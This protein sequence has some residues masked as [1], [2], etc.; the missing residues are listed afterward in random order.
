MISARLRKNVNGAIASVS[1][2]GIEV[3]TEQLLHD[4]LA[5]LSARG[6]SAWRDYIVSRYETDVFMRSSMAGEDVL[7]LVKSTIRA[8]V[9]PWRHAVAAACLLV[10]AGGV[11]V[12]I[13][14]ASSQSVGSERSVTIEAPEPSTMTPEEI[15][16]VVVNRHSFTDDRMG[17]FFDRSRFFR[18]R[19]AIPKAVLFAAQTSTNDDGS[20]SAGTLAAREFLGSFSMQDCRSAIME[21]ANLV[22]WKPSDLLELLEQVMSQ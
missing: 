2:G 20:I 19:E 3:F 8:R 15:R 12:S 21:H 4:D 1:V 16:L 6:P 22:G 14:K 7:M 13:G 18:V 10:L 17:R 9:F 11:C 5:E